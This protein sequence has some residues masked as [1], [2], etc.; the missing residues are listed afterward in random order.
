MVALGVS[1]RRVAAVLGI[2]ALG[3]ALC[4]APVLVNQL[5]MPAYL[6]WLG[7][8]GLV[9]CGGLRRQERADEMNKGSGHAEVTP[10]RLERAAGKPLSNL[11]VERMMDSTDELP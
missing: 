9:V 7:S 8:I 1:E 4:A 3:C 11:E 5:Q 2:I 10:D 6:L